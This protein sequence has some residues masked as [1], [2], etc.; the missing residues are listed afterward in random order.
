MK[1]NSIEPIDLGQAAKN[2]IQR[3][4]LPP[5]M[6]HYFSNP[7]W[8]YDCRCLPNFQSIPVDPIITENIDCEIVEPKQLPPCQ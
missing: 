5:H 6:Q 1:H 4:G 7:I 8:Q 3:G 2:E